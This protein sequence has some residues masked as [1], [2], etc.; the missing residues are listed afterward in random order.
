MS[1]LG[2][3]FRISYVSAGRE[4]L[5]GASRDQCEPALVVADPNYDLSDPRRTRE[6]SLEHAQQSATAALEPSEPE[7]QSLRG[8]VFERSPW[9]RVEGERVAALLGV[10]PLLGDA[11]I[12]TSVTSVGSPRILHIA[13]HGFFLAGDD[14]P[15]GS[16]GYSGL[17]LAGANTW[18][19]G[20]LPPAAAGTGLL[21]A[22]E[23]SRWNLRGTEIVVLSACVS[24]LGSVQLG[25]GVFGLRRAFALAGA[26]TVLLTLWNV[27]DEPTMLLVER[28]FENL[29]ERRLDRLEAL[30]DA[31]KYVRDLSVQQ[32]LD[33]PCAD[34]FRS[35]GFTDGS[36]EAHPFADP[37]FWGAFVLQGVGDEPL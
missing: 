31:Q 37:V 23:V 8:A 6:S 5:R 10:A 18:F 36:T 30:R 11:A 25:Q 16:L 7:R 35:E 2:E 34:G 12:V 28:F 4:L 27:S 13:T 17:A 21:T 15:A 1:F 33:H 22:D 14:D 32:L 26:R 19:G 9:M 3:R 20:V 29:I 24:G